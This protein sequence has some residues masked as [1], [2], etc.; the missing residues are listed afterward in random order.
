MLHRWKN[1]TFS[2]CFIVQIKLVFIILVNYKYYIGNLICVL[3]GYVEFSLTA[4]NY[5]NCLE[6]FIIFVLKAVLALELTHRNSVFCKHA[7]NFWKKVRPRSI[8][9]SEFGKRLRKVFF[10]IEKTNMREVY[11]LMNFISIEHKSSSVSNVKI[12]NYSILSLL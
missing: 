5:S 7:L 1:D 11:G 3:H 8:N 4:I 10:L 6:C 2:S 9:T 12:Q